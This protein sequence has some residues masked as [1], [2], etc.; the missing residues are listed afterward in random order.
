M[1]FTIKIRDT[2]DVTKAIEF[3]TFIKEKSEPT[4]TEK[5]SLV[6]DILQDMHEEDKASATS[7]YGGRVEPLA[8]HKTVAKTKTRHTWNQQE[9][10]LLLKNVRGGM[11]QLRSVLPH[12]REQQIQSKLTYMKIRLSDVAGKRKPR[13]Y[14]KKRELTEYNKFFAEHMKRLCAMGHDSKKAVEITTRAWQQRK[15]EHGFV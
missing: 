9:I 6:N 2:Q 14:K 13:L 3:L 10:T 4:T 11:S 8:E 7:L 15:K 1:E 5:K 12:L